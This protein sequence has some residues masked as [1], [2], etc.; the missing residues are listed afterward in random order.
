MRLQKLCIM[1]NFAEEFA[2]VGCLRL[3]DVINFCSLKR[4]GLLE[5]ELV[6]GGGGG[7]LIEG[8]RYCH[9]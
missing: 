1:F 8:F 5:R 2:F 3:G 4:E 7:G 9:M 6:W